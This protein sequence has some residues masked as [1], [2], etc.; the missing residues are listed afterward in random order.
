MKLSLMGAF[1]LGLIALAASYAPIQKIVSETYDIKSPTCF[2]IA[3]I[4]AFYL[5]VFYIALVLFLV[6]Y[7]GEIKGW[8]VE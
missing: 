7:L 4:I 8:C 2:C 3:N 5:I 1:I 6:V